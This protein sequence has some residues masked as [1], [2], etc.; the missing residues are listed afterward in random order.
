MSE[1]DL[2]E[3][4]GDDPQNPT[5]SLPCR[6][7]FKRGQKKIEVIGPFPELIEE[8]AQVHRDYWKK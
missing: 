7:V 2:L 3:L 4:T 6:E 1:V 8:I 5:F